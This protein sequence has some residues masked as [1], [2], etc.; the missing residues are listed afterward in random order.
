MRTEFKD[1]GKIKDHQEIKDQGGI[2]V[3]ALILH[4]LGLDHID[5]C[6]KNISTTIM[7]RAGHSLGGE[8]AQIPLKLLEMD[9]IVRRIHEALASDL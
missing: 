2:A 9:G 4:Y 7:S 8:S 1:Q 5:R 6:P 3:D